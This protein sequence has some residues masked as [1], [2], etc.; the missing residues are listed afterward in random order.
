MGGFNARSKSWWPDDII[1]PEGTDI[2]SL[3]TMHGLHQLILDPTHLLPNSFSCI[4]LI[5]AEQPNFAVDCGV[6]PPL[7]PYCHRKIIHCK[8]NLMIEYPPSH[9]HL[10]WDYNLSAQNAAAK[11]LDQVNWNFL[12]FSKNVHKP[13]SN[14]HRTLMN[15][16]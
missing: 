12:F 13:V 10:V 1:S 4:D 2:D 9:E 14:P 6:H 15:A 11:A 8:F 7:H 5:F 16:F 3:T